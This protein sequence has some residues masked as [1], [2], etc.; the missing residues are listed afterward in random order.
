MDYVKHIYPECFSEF[1]HHDGCFV[2][3]SDSTKHYI[4]GRSWDSCPLA[5]DDAWQRC[6]DVYNAFML[7]P[8]E[9]VTINS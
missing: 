8:W 5:W 9:I 4:V 1:E 7:P 6:V 2:I 3:Y